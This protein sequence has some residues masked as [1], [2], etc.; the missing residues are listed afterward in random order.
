M[1]TMPLVYLAALQMSMLRF[2][3]PTQKTQQTSPMPEDLPKIVQSIATLQALE[4]SPSPAEVRLELLKLLI[5]PNDLSWTA[6]QLHKYGDGFVN[7]VLT[8][9]FAP[10]SEQ[11]ESREQPISSTVPDPSTTHQ[12]SCV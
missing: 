9:Q 10:E 4:P 8:G 11:L 1:S 7:Y 2:S 12:P 5:C 6:R 3:L